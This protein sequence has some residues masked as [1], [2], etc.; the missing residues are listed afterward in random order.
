MVKVEKCSFAREEES[1]TECKNSKNL[2]DW[3]IYGVK[4]IICLSR[5]IGDRGLFF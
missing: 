5:M 2:S 4:N 1:E 3:E